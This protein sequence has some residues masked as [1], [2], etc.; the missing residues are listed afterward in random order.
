MYRIVLINISFEQQSTLCG[1]KKLIRRFG[2]E[3]DLIDGDSY[4]ECY[5]DSYF[6][7]YLMRVFRMDERA[8]SLI[9]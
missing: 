6:N 5:I 7:D 3:L 8:G 2:T 4:A 9:T 1:Y